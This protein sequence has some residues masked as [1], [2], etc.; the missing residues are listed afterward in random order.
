[1]LIPASRC[2]VYHPVDVCSYRAY[3]GN[4]AETALTARQTGVRANLLFAV[5]IITMNNDKLAKS[6][7]CV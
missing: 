6:Q 3:P 4:F 5:A 2:F 7:R 1:V